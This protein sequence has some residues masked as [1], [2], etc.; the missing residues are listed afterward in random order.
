MS[1]G[2]ACGPLQRLENIKLDLEANPNLWLASKDILT[3]VLAE[4]LPELEEN[5]RNLQ[6]YAETQR[7]LV[8]ELKMNA[9]LAAFKAKV[10]P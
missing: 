7:L 2:K 6:E 9:R 5:F 3:E 1:E 4:I 8:Q 10:T